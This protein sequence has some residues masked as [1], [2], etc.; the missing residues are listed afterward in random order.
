MRLDFY[1]VLFCLTLLLVG[2]TCFRFHPPL[3]NARRSAQSLRIESNGRVVHERLIVGTR[4]RDSF[5]VAPEVIDSVRAI[6]K[7]SFIM[8]YDRADR[9]APY[10][11]FLIE[12]E[13]D[14][15]FTALHQEHRG[16]TEDVQR[17]Y[18]TVGLYWEYP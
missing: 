1:T 14:T 7:G 10:L 13:R 17:I 18:Q 9:F 2:F 6:L 5:V 11:E 4:Q 8:V 16:V 3:D 12:R 15:S